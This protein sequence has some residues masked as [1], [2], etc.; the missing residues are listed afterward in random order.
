MARYFVKRDGSNNVVGGV[1]WPH[2]D[3]PEEMDDQDAEFV[4]YLDA[5]NN[6]PPNPL[7][8]APPIPVGNSIPALRDEV[9]AL[10]QVLI[11]VGLLDP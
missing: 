10:R 9:A 3:Y 2:T 8:K 1:K 7:R 6:P 11:D 5:V 4:A